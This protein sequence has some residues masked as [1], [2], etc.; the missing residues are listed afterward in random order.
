MVSIRSLVT[1]AALIAA[2]VMATLS[3]V[4]LAESIKGFTKKCQAVQ[5]PVQSITLTNAPLI[6]LGRGPLPVCSPAHAASHSSLFK[7][8]GANLMQTLLTSGADIFLTATAMIS[9]LPVDGIPQGAS[10]AELTE[11]LDAF[12]GVCSIHYIRTSN[13]RL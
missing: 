9:S 1:G 8:L 4:E 10:E 3:P 6:A 11:I 13:R 5:D 7:V 12:R 2:P